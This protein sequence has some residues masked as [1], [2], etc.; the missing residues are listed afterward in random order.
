L[1]QV[2]AQFAT[3]VAQMQDIL[4][5]NLPGVLSQVSTGNSNFETFLSILQNSAI[6]A[7]VVTALIVPLLWLSIFENW[8]S[9]IMEMRQ[10]RSVALQLVL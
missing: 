9:R 10:G 6:A 8:R 2:V 5:N 4:A 3:L 1:S 7:I